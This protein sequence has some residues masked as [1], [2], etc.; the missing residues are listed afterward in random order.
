ML[1]RSGSSGTTDGS[2]GLFS[3]GYAASRTN[4][5]SY[6]TIATLG[7]STDFGDITR[8]VADLGGCSDGTKSLAAGGDVGSA[9][10]VI[11]YVTIATTGNA[12]D[13]G[14]LS[15]A[16]YHLGGTSGD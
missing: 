6:I 4:H 16:G 14:D 7:D 8:A 1:F 3:G 15:L 10:N 13:F 2:R 12:V 5:I 9:S 11:D